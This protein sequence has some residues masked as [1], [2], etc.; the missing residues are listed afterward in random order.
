MSWMPIVRFEVGREAR[1]V[2]ED[3]AAVVREIS[4][5]SRT[6]SSM[7]RGSSASMSRSAMLYGRPR[8][9]AITLSRK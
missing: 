6:V 3:E 9:T 8:D 1:K 4:P 5:S 2:G 7:S